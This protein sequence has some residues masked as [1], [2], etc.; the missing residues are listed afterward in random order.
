MYRYKGQFIKKNNFDKK[1]KVIA[2]RHRVK[3]SNKSTKNEE[4]VDPNLCEGRR[5]VELKVLGKHLKCC[6]CKQVLSLENTVKEFH[7]GLN[8]ILMVKCNSCSA[9]T[10]VPTGK[11]HMTKNRSKHSDANTRAVL[12]EFF[13]LFFHLQLQK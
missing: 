7:N 13:T 5:I 2:A 12:G 1:L 3:L 6:K 9:T 8:S 10:E 11:I 4:Y